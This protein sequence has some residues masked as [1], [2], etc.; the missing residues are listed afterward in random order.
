MV[1]PLVLSRQN[2]VRAS[3][4]PAS[5]PT[6]WRTPATLTVLA[7]DGATVSVAEDDSTERPAKTQ[8][9]STKQ[10]LPPRRVTRQGARAA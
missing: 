6:G 2:T 9:P 4:A 10:G 8:P 3:F 5:G 7:R 1:M